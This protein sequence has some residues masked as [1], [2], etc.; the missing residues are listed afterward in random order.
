M[1]P[2]K[3]YTEK[4]SP[5]PVAVP[6]EPPVPGEWPKMVYGPGNEQKVVVSAEAQDALGK[7]W[8]ESPSDVE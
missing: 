6:F 4:V 2:K 5:A 3:S 1:A 8:N 7:D